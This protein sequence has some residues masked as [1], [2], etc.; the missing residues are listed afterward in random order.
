[1][2]KQ[3]LF[4]VSFFLDIMKDWLNTWSISSLHW[5]VEWSER[6]KKLLKSFGIFGDGNKAL[7]KKLFCFFYNEMMK[8][9]FFFGNNN[10]SENITSNSYISF[11]YLR[12]VYSKSR[13]GEFDTKLYQNHFLF[14]KKMLNLNLWLPLE[15]QSH[16]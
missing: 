3:L 11:L 10:N 7:I 16:S 12:V 1:M 14:F 9:F 8:W 2:G 5:R 6:T 4:L 15:I 13:L